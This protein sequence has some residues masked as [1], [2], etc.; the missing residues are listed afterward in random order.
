MY[1]ILKDQQASVRAVLGNSYE[2][3]SQDNYDRAFTEKARSVV[4]ETLGIS[5]PRALQLLVALETAI[6]IKELYDMIVFGLLS[7][8]P[9]DLIEQEITPS[10]S[11]EPIELAT[12]QTEFI[13]L[14]LYT[15]SLD[16]RNKV[17]EET[18]DKIKSLFESE[19]ILTRN[20]DKY[21]ITPDKI[22][23]NK[24]FEEQ[25]GKGKTDNSLK[26]NIDSSSSKQSSPNA[27]S[28]RHFRDFTAS[29]RDTSRAGD[30]NVSES[31]SR[32]C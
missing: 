29:A 5:E 31:T 28:D 11:Y 17:Y 23:W 7:F 4:S 13:F 12:N 2:P 8:G 1:F 6:Q 16:K 24:S 27:N 25:F 26:L 15:V 30:Y 9:N 3:F 14:F 10:L 20:L 32:T 22:D 18:L 19:D 21:K